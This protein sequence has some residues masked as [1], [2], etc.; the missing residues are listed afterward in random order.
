M[1]QPP[2]EWGPNA[3][4][5]A[6]E[7]LRRSNLGKWRPF[8]CPVSEC[9]G[10]HHITAD[11]SQ[12]CDDGYPHR[13]FLTEDQRWI[14]INEQRD[15]GGALLF[16]CGVS[17]TPRDAWV[18]PHGRADQHPPP[19]D[20]WL[21]WL[22]LAGRG[23][24]KTR[25]GSEWTHRLAKKYPEARMALISPT[26]PDVR[27]TMVE[28]ESGILATAPPGMVPEWE[29]SKKKL[30]WPNGFT[31]YGYSGEEPDRLRGKQHH[32]GWI[33]EPA[34][35]PLI[36][37]VWYNFLLGLRLGVS[38]RVCLT[39]SPLPTKWLKDTIKDPRTVMRRATT[40]ANLRNLPLHYQQTVLSS[41]EGTRLAKQ[42]I[43]GLLLEDVEGAL[44]TN[45]LIDKH[46]IAPKDLPALDRVVIAC[47]PAGT[48][49]SGSD[50][51]GIGAVGQAGDETY[52]LADYSGRYSP[53][54]WAEKLL[55]AYD[56][57]EADAIVVEVTYGRD[58]VVQNLTSACERKGRPL[59]RIITIDSRRGKVLR[60]EPVVALYERGQVHHVGVLEELETQQTSWVPGSRSPD[61]ID[62]LVHGVTEV[63][64]GRSAGTITSPY[65]LLRANVPSMIER[66]TA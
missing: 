16:R 2:Q 56:L 12:V 45:A 44:W 29:P 47:D 4:E 21:I 32:F 57:H 10:N 65:A 7:E 26:A 38:P 25:S 54:D 9:D 58:M 20:D 48:A 66:R 37:E 35:I 28:G 17:G 46:R 14:C 63:S 18:F 6:L 8:Y 40:Y 31:A 19:G 36:T 49:R 24:G 64:R 55:W 53:N 34:H 22:L 60:A 11:G 61:R 1:V 39:T 23:A 42:E 33:D 30:T 3:Q 52:V 27:D 50:E 59:P 51:T 43:L 5:R 13:W 62:M 41:F 15:E